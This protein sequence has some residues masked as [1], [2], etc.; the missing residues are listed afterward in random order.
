MSLKLYSIKDTELGKDKDRTW[1][2]KEKERRD[3]EETWFR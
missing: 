2:G 1:R 3:K